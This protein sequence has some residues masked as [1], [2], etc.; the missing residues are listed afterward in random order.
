MNG[1]ETEAQRAARILVDGPGGVEVKQGARIACDNCRQAKI[2]CSS[3]TDG[4][5]P[6]SRCLK[7]QKPCLFYKHQ[8]GRKPGRL[9]NRTPK[10]EGANEGDPGS[11]DQEDENDSLPLAALSSSHAGP[12]NTHKPPTQ[13][14]SSGPRA[15][16]SGASAAGA[17]SKAHPPGSSKARHS[18]P[19]GAA[20]P[21]Q[22]SGPNAHATA[23]AH[24]LAGGAA[25]GKKRKRNSTDFRP[26]GPAL[27]TNHSDAMSNSSPNFQ[28]AH[29]ARAPSPAPSRGST[30]GSTSAANQRNRRAGSTTVLVPPALLERTSLSA[31]ASGSGTASRTGSRRGSASPPTFGPAS[32]TSKMLPPLSS[33]Q[34]GQPG[35]HASPEEVALAANSLLWYSSSSS[36]S[37]GGGPNNAGPGNRSQQGNNMM[38]QN[39]GSGAP[40]TLPGMNVGIAAYTDQ[41]SLGHQ[42]P[43][44]S[45]ST[46]VPDLSVLDSVGMLDP[47]SFMN[48]Y[49]H[50]DYDRQRLLM[51]IYQAAQQQ[52]DPTLASSTALGVPP[53]SQSGP[54]VDW[55]RRLQEQMQQASY[56]P[57]QIAAAA[58][59]VQRIHNVLVQQTQQHQ[60]QQAVQQ[61]LSGK[62]GSVQ[63][64]S[65][66]GGGTGFSG[67][68]SAAAP[69]A[70]HG[71]GHITIP[72]QPPHPSHHSVG[73]HSMHHS[74]HQRGPGGDGSA[75]SSTMSPIAPFGSTN[76]SS[77]PPNS[78]SV[79]QPQKGYAPNSRSG[80]A[81]AP[82]PGMPGYPNQFTF[83]PQPSTP[84]APS[85]A[86][87]HNHAQ[88]GHPSSQ[89]SHPGGNMSTQAA[90][91]GMMPPPPPRQHGSFQGFESGGQARMAGAGPGAA[92][93]VGTSGPTR[94]GSFGDVMYSAGRNPYSSGM[95]EGVHGRSQSFGQV[96]DAFP[97]YEQSQ[98]QQQQQG[99]GMQHHSSQLHMSGRKVH[100][101]S[102][103]GTG[104]MG[105]V[106]PMPP[107]VHGARGAN[108]PSALKADN[109]VGGGMAHQSPGGMVGILM[110]ADGG[111]GN[112][113]AS[114][115]RSLSNESGSGSGGLG[116][117]IK[118]ARMEGNVGDRSSRAI[119]EENEDGEEME[120]DREG[121]GPDQERGEGEE[122][123]GGEEEEDDDDDEDDDEDDD[124]DDDDDVL[125]E[126]D[127]NLQADDHVL[128]NPL[129][130]LAHASGAAAAMDSGEQYRHAAE[131]MG[132]LCVRRD[133]AHKPVSSA[134]AGAEGNKS[135][136]E[137][138]TS[139][140]DARP[141]LPF[142]EGPSKRDVSLDFYRSSRNSNPSIIRSFPS[143]RNR[144]LDLGSLPSLVRNPPASTSASTSVAASVTIG[145]PAKRMFRYPRT[146]TDDPSWVLGPRPLSSNVA[147]LVGPQRRFMRPGGL[148]LSVYRSGPPPLPSSMSDSAIGSDSGPG[149]PGSSS[150]FNPNGL[151]PIRPARSVGGSANGSV[152]DD[153][154][155][156]A[157]DGDER[158]SQFPRRP[159]L[160]FESSA[161]R[162]TGSD[163][164]AMDEREG[165]HTGL[166]V[167]RSILSDTRR[168]SVV[169]MGSH[170]PVQHSMSQ[171][172]PIRPADLLRQEAPGEMV[173]EDTRMTF[174][175]PEPLRKDS[176]HGAVTAENLRTLDAA[177]DGKAGKETAAGIQG[178]VDGKTDGG[179][180][181]AKPS[182]PVAASAA[183][184]KESGAVQDKMDIDESSDSKAADAS[185][186]P[187][188]SNVPAVNEVSTSGA[189]DISMHSEGAAPASL[190]AVKTSEDASKDV[191]TPDRVQNPAAVV[192]SANKATADD[193]SI[194]PAMS[195]PIRRRR[196]SLSLET[197]KEGTPSAGVF[198]SPIQRDHWEY[199]DGRAQAR[200][201][202]GGSVS[203]G[204]GVPFQSLH[205]L[206]GIGV[207]GGKA[208]T[209]AGG[210]TPAMKPSAGPSNVPSPCP[211]G[212]GEFLPPPMLPRSGLP[213]KKQPKSCISFD[214][215][216]LSPHDI[217]GRRKR[218]KDEKKKEKDRMKKKKSTAGFTDM[219]SRSKLTIQTRLQD[220]GKDEIL[221]NMNDDESDD[222]GFKRGYFNVS[223]YHQKLDVDPES[224]DPVVKGYLDITEVERL[225]DVFFNNINPLLLVFDPFLHSVNYVRS[226]SAFLT[227]V[228]ISLAARFVDT[229]R[230]AALAVS[231]EHLWLGKQLPLILAGG[232]K[233]VEISQ[234]FIILAMFHKPT[235]SLADDRSWQY[236]GF[237]IRIATE[238]GVNRRINPKESVKSK[239]QVRRRV[240]NR[241]RLWCNLFLCDRIMSAQTGRPWTI[242]DDLLMP[243]ASADW[244]TQDFALPF[245]TVVVSMIRLRRTIARHSTE[246]DSHL[247]KEHLSLDK[248]SSALSYLEFLRHGAN[249]DLVRWRDSWS[250]T[251]NNVEPESAD[252]GPFSTHWTPLS[253]LYHQHSWLH[254]NSFVLQSLEKHETV[255]S[256]VYKDCWTAALE[257]I[258]ITLQLGEAKLMYAPNHIIVMA[259]YAAVSL[260]RL[261][262]R[263]KSK[264]PWVNR[265]EAITAVR[266]LIKTLSNAGKTPQH[267]NGAA[268]P[269]AKYLTSVLAL[270]DPPSKEQVEENKK[271]KDPPRASSP[272]RLRSV[273][274]AAAIR[275]RP[276]GEM[277][278]AS[279]NAIVMP[280]M[281]EGRDRKAERNSLGSNRLLPSSAMLSS[282]MTHSPARPFTS[283]AVPSF[284]SMAFSSLPLGT[285]EASTLTPG[286]PQTHPHP[287]PINVDSIE[288]WA[289]GL[290][291]LAIPSTPTG[292]PFGLNQSASAPI[293]ALSTPGLGADTS[294]DLSN[295]GIDMNAAVNSAG[296]GMAAASNT[297]GLG[298]PFLGYDMGTVSGVSGLNMAG[299]KFPY[300][301]R[302]PF[303]FGTVAP[304]TSSIAAA[305]PSSVGP[306]MMRAPHQQRHVSG[307]HTM[308]TSYVQS[309]RA[310]AGGRNAGNSNAVRMAPPGEAF[311]DD[312]N[313]TLPAA[314]MDGAMPTE[315]GLADGGEHDR[316]WDYLTSWDGSNAGISSGFWPAHQASSNFTSY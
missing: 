132:L 183:L 68:N 236:L 208:H 113:P 313:W 118:R 139:S 165:A 36:S 242:S 19:A 198:P 245:D 171:P 241:E 89:M 263:D 230:D 78:P 213:F 62:P 260:L 34:H 121:A 216:D 235:R 49:S 53:G 156:P 73:T 60:Q 5:V 214:R 6:C 144:G 269:Y 302:P 16:K 275:M 28:S 276:R 2:K 50:L 37:G 91:P 98:Q 137:Q 229:N 63:P 70:T 220:D 298:P 274:D 203:S 155:G 180:N 103:V 120:E 167:R 158:R 11:S 102:Q 163:K 140:S 110:N 279:S 71:P 105:A 52:S 41:T 84:T 4:Q 46:S 32:P 80:I 76:F 7:A 258:K 72:S 252:L 266:E 211:A 107:F 238:I 168:T 39:N 191:R 148:D 26:T 284:P 215:V 187:A 174:S 24:Q 281:A 172:S 312:A 92:L 1:Q 286:H 66:H 306:T 255:S 169:G 151:G 135:A 185:K 83:P 96:Y 67:P 232:Y 257:L 136:D 315:G 79:L 143:P 56:D 27:F 295:G 47:N 227:T 223:L 186:A 199:K 268:V 265:D 166:G 305:G 300:D 13:P 133:E 161:S 141:E 147:A 154:G 145:P 106:G 33:G 294:G 207:R 35:R 210:L 175:Q 254:L 57:S 296:P 192:T 217:F 58:A 205:L 234:A 101:V 209:V 221:P 307:G 194:S 108:R 178:K 206:P 212:D 30:V 256:S 290:N 270:W 22:F 316:I 25:A 247:A 82:L 197:P 193:P 259:V 87:Q 77:V 184:A 112:G 299:V 243:E 297:S 159:G 201:A 162:S 55:Q 277:A 264:H 43:L 64:Q 18:M 244:H 61:M 12:S 164:G 182:N 188:S 100:P 134:G 15:N 119:D 282:T 40:V 8:R 131:T 129:R 153:D 225:F 74:Q 280:T 190:I 218:Q 189:G 45:A 246:L 85:N 94:S 289:G 196:F 75:M 251:S 250:E 122:G 224:E 29:L 93:H 149:R 59:A 261:L 116:P 248:D 152:H 292:D 239:E 237:A 202:K 138:P 278:S 249:T 124:D 231:L 146:L 273:S 271:S 69:T 288:A 142:V 301:G 31:S 38:H 125:S 311:L 97:G 44:S 104:P 17:A 126:E 272:N 114:R 287:H 14:K 309:D 293:T 81:S 253:K 177:M 21:G 86:P 195:P 308:P 222:D 128:S 127:D 240:R 54:A 51:P 267:R 310:S 219:S 99:A 291:A 233:S 173:G 111:A 48:A 179:A 88:V 170:S 226:R 130:L 176:R 123:T 95:A 228:I 10:K 90:T 150:T 115:L 283:Q 3:P 109:S 117:S 304:S 65:A 303:P 204:S 262:N 314:E 160:S 9:N 20:M 181:T 42:Q 157:A 200:R 23:A 285:P